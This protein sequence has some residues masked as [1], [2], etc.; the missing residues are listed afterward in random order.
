[1][2]GSSTRNIRRALRQGVTQEEILEIILQVMHYCGWPHLPRTI[3]GA[4]EVF[5]PSNK[6]GKKVAITD[7]DSERLER[8]QSI[9]RQLGW[10]SDKPGS[11][12]GDKATTDE[13]N[14]IKKVF[15]DF[16]EMTEKYLMGDI[17]SRPGL[18]LRE[19]VMVSMAAIIAIGRPVGLKPLL[20][21]AAHVDI[22]R[23]EILEIIMQAAHYCGW[24]VAV[25]AILQFNEVLTEEDYSE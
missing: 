21:H 12:Y 23:Q 25:Q 8:G 11:E 4:K 19:R 22:S 20:R 18:G 6:R 2:W 14:I 9:R 10:Y 1:M 3:L 7:S 15:P 16:W 24:P 13:M 17:W 5:S